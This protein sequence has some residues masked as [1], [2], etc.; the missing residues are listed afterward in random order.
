MGQ[1]IS[2]TNIATISGLTMEQVLDKMV[3]KK[4]GIA[5]S[6]TS[7]TPGAS[8]SGLVSGKLIAGETVQFDGMYWIVVHT[9]YI[10][11]IAYLGSTVIVTAVAFGSSEKYKGSTLATVAANFEKSMSSEALSI[12]NNVTVNDVT[13]KVFVPSLEQVG[14]DFS[15][16]K[17]EANRICKYNGDVYYWWTSSKYYNN[18]RAYYVTQAGGCTDNHVGN[19]CGFRPF[20]A[21]SL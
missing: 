19:I 2:V 9:D 11:R 8:G 17:Q 21:L 13:A 5:G 4:I 6:A 10:K 16:F 1:E 12:M 7:T 3:E 20:I 15:Y 14:G 18:Y